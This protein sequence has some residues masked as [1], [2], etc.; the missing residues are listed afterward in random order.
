[1]RG[2]TVAVIGADGAGKTTVCR[3]VV[4]SL[5][6]PVRYLYMGVN[7]EAS[8]VMLPT[9]RIVRALKRSRGGP[10]AGGPPDPAREVRPKGTVGRGIH[11][12]R[13]SVSLVLRLAEEW[14][15]QVLAWSHVLR[16][17]VVLF[18]RHFFTDYYAH[19]IV[20]TSRTER[21]LARRI[22][23][24]VLERL[25]PRPDLV[26]LLDAPAEVLW[27]RKPEGTFEAVA[28]R[29]EEYL[30]LGAVCRHFVTV[31]A[32]QPRA[33]VLRRVID[34]IMSHAAKEESKPA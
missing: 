27:K 2:F 30:E 3:E 8:N 24:Y 28:R 15:R 34:L 1:M 19:D 11:A 20:G 21:S 7:T 32:T 12:L 6:I 16:G 26:I 31:D 14:Y 17:R 33:I 23:G 29:R 18:D 4:A 25:Y 5:P 10:P 22:H 9:T 13:A